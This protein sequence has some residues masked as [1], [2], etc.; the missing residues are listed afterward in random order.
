MKLAR[1]FEQSTAIMIAI[2]R[3]P[4]NSHIP[5]N[6]LA[7]KLKLSPT[8]SQKL[9]RKL[10]LAGLI[11][12]SP[13]VGGGF[14]MAKDTNQISIVDIMQAVDETNHTFYSTGTLELAAG[15][16]KT[17]ANDRISRAFQTADLVWLQVLSQTKLSDL[18]LN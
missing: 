16:N 15:E 1:S 5:A 9:L 7:S 18:L 8:Y 17:G 11:K 4:T 13:G 14:L 12:A 10:V 6:V 2:A 3:Q